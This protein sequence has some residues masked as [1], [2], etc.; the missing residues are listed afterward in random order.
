MPRAKGSIQAVR[1][2]ILEAAF[3]AFREKG[4]AGATTREIAT[5]AKVSKRDLYTLFPDKQTMLA[6]CI[7]ITAGTGPRWRRASLGAGG[8]RDLVPARAEPAG[9]GRALPAGD[10]GGRELARGRAGADDVRQGGCRRN[11]HWVREKG[12]G[13]AAARQRQSLGHRGGVHVAALGEQH[14]LASLARGGAARRS[15]C[16]A[17]GAGSRRGASAALSAGGRL[18][19][20][21]ESASSFQ[22]ERLRHPP[23]GRKRAQPRPVAD[24]ARHRRAGGGVAAAL[25]IRED[26]AQ[27]TM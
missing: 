24:P 18:E 9:G 19:M 14:G 20:I 25:R 6:A 17:A 12:P 21:R 15:G 10:H 22:V 27:P 1:Q 8:L 7:K 3:A 5:R 23:P 2:R 11:A 13:R 16:E 26:G 4:Y